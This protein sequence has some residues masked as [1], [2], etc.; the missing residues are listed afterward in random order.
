[1]IRIK[2]KAAVDEAAFRSGERLTITDVAEATGLSRTT[3]NRIANLPGHNVELSAVDALCK[4]F[5]CQP[6]DLLEYV[7]DDEVPAVKQRY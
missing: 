2:L 4:Y 1:M 7:P 3:L 6:G 5:R